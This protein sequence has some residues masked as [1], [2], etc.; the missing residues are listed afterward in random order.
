MRNRNLLVLSIAAILIV[1]VALLSLAPQEKRMV[2]TGSTVAPV[3]T[4][5]PAET[6]A[7]SE[8]ASTEETADQQQSTPAEPASAYLLVTVAGVLYE[9][10]PIYEEGEYTIRQGED[11]ENVIH[12]TPDSVH[13]KSSTCDNQDCVLQGT[14]TL[15]NIT[16]RV[17]A[18]MI[19]CLPNEI[20]LEL[21][22][23]EGLA[24]V[25]MQIESAQ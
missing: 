1:L 13:M 24:D 7:P 20:T 17:L 19:I 2:Q 22:T 11:K 25:L 5:A 4:S 23:P 8:N 9:P 3:E 14:V 10:I 21:Y 16:E 18:N 12:V 15:E 6:A